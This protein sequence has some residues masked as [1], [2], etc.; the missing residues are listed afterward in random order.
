ME[1][2]DKN[3]DLHCLFRHRK[4]AAFGDITAGQSVWFTCQHIPQK[5]SYKCFRYIG[6][7]IIK[8]T[9]TI[10]LPTTCNED[11]PHNQEKIKSQLKGTSAPPHRHQ[12]LKNQRLRNSYTHI[13]GIYH[14]ELKKKK[15][16]TLT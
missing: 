13:F 7:S 9:K 11:L 15:K 14:N 2:E 6:D 16:L 5:F 3:Q 1:Y 4:T 8:F 10:S 12:G